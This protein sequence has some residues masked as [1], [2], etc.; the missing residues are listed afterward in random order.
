MV[1]MVP[2]LYSPEAELLFLH[3]LTSLAKPILMKV[4]TFKEARERKIFVKF[5]IFLLNGYHGNLHF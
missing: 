4:G 3:N 2:T 1:A 5:Q